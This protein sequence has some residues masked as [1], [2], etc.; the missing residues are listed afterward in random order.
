MK[1]YIDFS[2]KNKNHFTAVTL[3]S[4]L[5]V[6]PVKAKQGKKDIPCLMGFYNT[7]LTR[8]DYANIIKSNQFEQVYNLRDLF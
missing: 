2:V 3:S 8:L 4:L 7:E 5:N 1:I 6:F